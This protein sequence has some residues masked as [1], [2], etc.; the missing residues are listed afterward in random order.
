M[1]IYLQG[2]AINGFNFGFDFKYFLRENEIKYGIDINGFATKFDFFNSVGRQ[3]EQN[4]NT[5][6]LAG[7]IDSKIDKRFIGY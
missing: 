7:Y 3:I 1:E 5:T 6:E 2:L 4:Q